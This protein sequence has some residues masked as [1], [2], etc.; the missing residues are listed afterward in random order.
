MFID[1]KSVVS[2]KK[3][4]DLGASFYMYGSFVRTHLTKG[5]FRDIDIAIELPSESQTEGLIRLSQIARSP[6]RR[7]NWNIDVFSA[8]SPTFGYNSRPESPL[9]L[10]LITP[11][12]LKSN[13]ALSLSIKR[14][15]RRVTPD[16]LE[17]LRDARSQC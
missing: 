4:I 9:H 10:L 5:K 13:S 16:N 11:S 1:L 6:E 7:K 12:E 14:Y 15:F 8:N 17:G 2:D 3:L